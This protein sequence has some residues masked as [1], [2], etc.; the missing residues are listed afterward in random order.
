MCTVRAVRHARR[1]ILDVRYT[2]DKQL[3]TSLLLVFC[4]KGL[5]DA[6]A[7]AAE[8]LICRLAAGPLSAHPCRT[9]RKYVRVGAYAASMPR[10]VPRRWAGKDQWRWSVCTV[11]AVRHARCPI[12][13][14][15]H[16]RDKQLFTSLLLVLCSKGLVDADASAA[17]R[18]ICRLAAGPLPAHPRRTRRKYV[19]VGSYA[20]SMPRKVPRRWAGK[21]QWRW[22]VCTVRAVRNARCPILDVRHTRDKQ[23]FTWPPT[24]LPVRCALAGCGT[25]GGMDAARAPPRK[26]SRRVARAARARAFDNHALKN[27]AAFIPCIAR[28]DRAHV[29]RRWS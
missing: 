9:R 23:L 24:N 28:T 13:D 8:R 6:D 12:L 4:S 26:D 15:R 22:S 14:V 19:R 21:D 10:K 25:L 17:E 29:H 1:P 11:R 18:L 7:S 2:R 16:T 5:G 20:V 3:F 27:S